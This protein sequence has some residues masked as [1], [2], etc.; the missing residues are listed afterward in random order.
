M[1]SMNLELLPNQIEAQDH[2]EDWTVGALFM[3]MGT[4]KTR[5]AI[6]IVNKKQVDLV[7][8]VGPLRTLKPREGMPSVI[9]EINK[10][11][12]FKCEK[13]VYIGIETIQASDR[14]Y[15]QLYK[16][17]STAWNCF[18]VV[19]ESLKIKNFEAKRT[20]RLLELSKMVKY[21]LILNGTPLSK[22]LIDLWSQMQFLSPLILN[23]S[24]AEFKNTFCEYTKVTKTFGHRSYTKEFITGYDN[25]DYLYSLIR[26]Y[27]FECDLKLQIKKYYNDIPYVLD[28]EAKKEY[29]FLKEKYLDDE[30]LLEKNNNIFL[31]MTSKMQ[32]AYCTSEGKFEALDE[33]F[34]T[35]DQEDTIIYC[36]FIASREAC[37][38]RYPNATVLSY[39][40]ESLGLN[41]QHL[42]NTIYFDKIWD[43]ALRNQSAA[44]TYRTG[45]EQ[46]CRYWDLTGNVGLE[47]LI[48]KNILK[49][50]GM[51]EYF[52]TKSKEQ[53]KREL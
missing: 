7:V 51:T 11:G 13:V 25:I 16:K 1:K 3:E 15:L 8:W 5:T 44:R 33:L 27:I 41:L 18:I 37:E 26:H 52:K 38:L 23:M 34:E 35:I 45:Q 29:D 46:D 19:D 20:Q 17:I 28:D 49:K 40:K 14:Q 50:V 10:W 6:E 22:S 4:G 39:Q 53:L 21:K 47:K 36:R 24:M 43:L 2:L 12:G 48:D 30:E 32:H 9:D 42:K 31:E